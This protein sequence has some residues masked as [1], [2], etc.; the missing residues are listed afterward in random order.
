M[1]VRK[2]IETLTPKYGRST[3][4]LP[5]VPC[6]LNGAKVRKEWKARKKGADTQNTPLNVIPIMLH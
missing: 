5:R 3:L 6:I 4:N 2:L 1:Y